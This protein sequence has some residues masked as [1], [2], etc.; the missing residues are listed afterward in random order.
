MTRIAPDLLHAVE[1]AIA[2]A[3]LGYSL[4]LTSLIDDVSTFTLVIGDDAPCTFASHGEALDY[5]LHRQTEA[6]A[7]A[8]IADY[9]AHRRPDFIYNPADWDVTCQWNNWGP[10]VDDV[11]LREPLRLRTL[12]E[13]PDKWV[14]DI[15]VAWDD[16]GTPCERE[17]RM[18]DSEEAAK[19]ALAATIPPA[20]VNEIAARNAAA[21]ARDYQP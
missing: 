6:R 19:A 10:L 12:F 11:D 3:N 13:G 16:D 5:V 20:P 4:K 1:R 15:P 21:I 17:A 8:A 7:Q 18:F 14:T 9:E 2:D